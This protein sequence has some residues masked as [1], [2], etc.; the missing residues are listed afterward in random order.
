MEILND[1]IDII[2]YIRKEIEDNYSL[3]KNEREAIEW[4]R[5]LKV[6]KDVEEVESLYKEIVD[7]YC[8]EFENQLCESS[9]SYDA[10]RIYL[11]REYLKAAYKILNKE[12]AKKNETYI[13]EDWEEESIG[14]QG[15]LANDC[16]DS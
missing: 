13:Q 12:E 15:I 16:R 1:L 3:Q 4:Y 8:T 5:Y 14:H 9:S 6:H 7:R 10:K 2:V 11:L